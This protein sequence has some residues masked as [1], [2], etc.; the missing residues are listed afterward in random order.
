[1]FFG[2]KQFGRE[3]IRLVPS[4]RIKQIAGRAGRFGFGADQGVA[5][6]LH[7]QD[8]EYFLDCMKTPNEE[9]PQ[10]GMAPP[11]SLIEALAHQFTELPL[12]A[13]L[14]AITDGGKYKPHFA[15]CISREQKLIVHLLEE[16]PQ[17]SIGEK[18][19]LASAPVNLRDSNLV[20]AF[21]WFVSCLAERRP[22]PLRV[23]LRHHRQALDYL[24]MAESF[25]RTLD[26]Y[27]WLGSRFPETYIEREQVLEKRE[28]CSALVEKLLG[29]ITI[30]RQAE[31][32]S[33]PG[34]HRHEG[35][36][37]REQ[38]ESDISSL[39]KVLKDMESRTK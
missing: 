31:L 28:L 21:H 29:R 30:D 22:C 4:S 27:L 16:F 11:A 6:C 26:L 39:D 32:P 36:L 13:I 8:M 15:P 12:T 7:D 34:L 19:L 5:T 24:A 23:D 20:N 17:L 33:I 18:L 37:L 35:D 1:M 9:Y 14:S 3:G 38:P 2:V 10:A 25:Y